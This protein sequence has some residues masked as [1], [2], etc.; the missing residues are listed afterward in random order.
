MHRPI[1]SRRRGFTLLEI[2]VVTVILALLAGGVTV[3][4]VR[5]VA[6]A[7]TQRAQSDLYSLGNALEQYKLDNHDY[8]STEQGLKALVN[9]P[10]GQPEP[11]GWTG[12]YV[13]RVPVDPWGRPYRY[14]Y[15]GKNNQDGFD[16]WSLGRNDQEGG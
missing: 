12:R 14:E 1:R 8:P 9:K 2:M 15:P 10:S 7:R 6:Q 11:A 5:R 3:L 4:V 13:K 16:L